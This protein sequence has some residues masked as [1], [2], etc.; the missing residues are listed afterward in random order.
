[1]YQT[2]IEVNFN[3]AINWEN[4]RL[5]RGRKFGP[6]AYHQ[7]V[8]DCMLGGKKGDCPVFNVVCDNGIRFIV[9]S[10]YEPANTES[11]MY[12]VSTKKID[13]ILGDTFWV[14]VAEVGKS[15]VGKHGVPK[16]GKDGKRKCYY[17]S[18]SDYVKNGDVKGYVIE[19]K[20]APV[21]GGSASIVSSERFDEE[22]Y[23]DPCK[24]G[25]NIPTAAYK[26]KLDKVVNLSD[27]MTSHIG[28]K[29]FL[30]IGCIVP[31]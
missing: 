7:I 1:M 4:T 10:D 29:K 12:T 31:M 28:A 3:T 2:T 30:G 15:S 25:M 11:D 5:G 18:M 16:I 6:Y 9:N 13:S 23:S 27:Y 22:L 17:I 14:R 20:I 19:K 21:F 8:M 24:P 26:V